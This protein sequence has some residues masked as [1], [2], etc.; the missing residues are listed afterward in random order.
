MIITQRH[1]DFALAITRNAMFEGLNRE[2]F[3]DLVKAAWIVLEANIEARRLEED[4][5]SERH[6]EVRND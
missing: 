6:S 1:A 3:I 4:R 5:T 2:Q